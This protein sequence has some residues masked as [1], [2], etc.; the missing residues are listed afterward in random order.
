M[1]AGSAD[2][3]GYLNPGPDKASAQAKPSLGKAGFGAFGLAWIFFQA[4][5]S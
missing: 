3:V 5:G 4:K 2:G 1:S